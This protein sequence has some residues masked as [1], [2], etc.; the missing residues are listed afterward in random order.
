MSLSRKAFDKLNL[1]EK[2]EL[3][4]NEGDFIASR[5]SASHFV[6]LFALDGEYVEMWMS[7][8]LNTLMWIEI[9]QNDETLKMY[10]EH[11]DP[12]KDLGL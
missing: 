1:S 4:Q 11:L 9:M 6:H 5:Q 8:E 7:I 3:L 10:T 2:F 12:K